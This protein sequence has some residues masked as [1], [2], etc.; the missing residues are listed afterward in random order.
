MITKKQYSILSIYYNDIA[1]W[2]NDGF[3]IS[4]EK[5]RPI[6]NCFGFIKYYKVYVNAEYSTQKDIV[7]AFKHLGV[8]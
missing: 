8:I 7:R 1:Y 3:S 5:I 2:L 6:K 4:I